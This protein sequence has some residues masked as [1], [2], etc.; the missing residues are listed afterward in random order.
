MNKFSTFLTIFLF[1]FPAYA[2]E[3]IQ[4][5]IQADVISVYDGDTITVEAQIWVRQ[6]ITTK[7]RIRG[8]DTPEIRGKCSNE[9][10]LAIKA[11]DFIRA[12]MGETVI[13]T[14]IEDGKY[15]G[16]VIADVYTE[17]GDLVSAALLK[18]NLGRQYDGGQRQ[19]WCD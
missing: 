7:V 13:L 4:G 11:R 9:K 10:E 12:L 5:P 14:N 16:R 17:Q 19:G 3:V 18:E 6:T 15:A 2:Q 1:S 8:V